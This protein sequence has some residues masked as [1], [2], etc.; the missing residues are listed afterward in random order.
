MGDGL[1]YSTFLGGSSSNSGSAIAVDSDGNAYVAGRTSSADFPVQN[2]YQ[3]S[4]AAGMSNA[5]ITKLN[6]AG[7]A[8]VFS[9]YL[10]GS[11]YDVANSLAVDPSRNITAVRL[12][13]AAD[14]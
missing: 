12:K 14:R 2:A 4:I 6:S 11:G 7:S 9:T 5:F 1:I 13:F 10:G 8:L 3:P